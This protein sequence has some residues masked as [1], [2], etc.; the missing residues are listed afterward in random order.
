M[1]THDTPDRDD[2]YEFFSEIRTCSYC[3]LDSVPKVYGDADESIEVCPHCKAA[4][5]Y[6]PVR[7]QP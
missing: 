2:E 3:G 1:K 7:R 5:C 6:E 4:E